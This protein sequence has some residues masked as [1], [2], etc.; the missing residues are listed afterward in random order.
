MS[1][2]VISTLVSGPPVIVVGSGLAGL[3]AATHLINHN[4][5]VQ[6]LD[7]FPKAGGNS[8]KASSGING[9]PTRFQALLDSTEAF[10]NDTIKSAGLAFNQ[11]EGAEKER[12]QRLVK[13]L[14]DDSQSAIYWLADEQGV[15]LSSVSVLG[16]HSAPR[17]H[18]GGPG[19]KPPGFSIVSTLLESLKKSPLFNLKLNTKVTK[20]LK[21]GEE[22]IGVE[23]Q[24][25]T[26]NKKTERIEGP[27]IF[28]SGGFAGDTHGLV[29]QYRPD[30]VG[31]PT[32]NDYREGTQPLLQEIGAGVV[33][34]KEVHVHPT[35]FVDPADPTAHV[36]ILAAEVLRGEGGILLAGT[37]ERFVNELGTRAQVTAAIQ[38]NAEMIPVPADAKDPATQQ[39]EVWLVLDK[40]SAEKMASH[41]GFYRFK[42]LMVDMTIGDLS[43]H[44]PNALETIR[45]YSRNIA[46][47]TPDPFG[48]ASFGS[49]TLEEVDES[50]P[51]TAGR[52]TPV[53]HF[54]MGGV[55]IDSDATVINTE[56]EK[57]EGLWAAGEITGGLHGDNRLG[58]SS[59][60]ECV[61]FGRRAG[62]EAATW[63]KEHY[64][65]AREGQKQQG[66][67]LQEDLRKE[68]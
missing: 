60:L 31:Y 48:R 9:A 39:W 58:G 49:W 61:V 11:A 2:S 63:W 13:T 43:K 28:A 62:N 12:R 51:I 32:T 27:V 22:V 21:E 1:V 59:L 4:V 56:G 52:I 33:D 46:T 66:L 47:S 64:G 8:I 26:D 50:T 30:L 15:D 20:V 45:S 14:V 57:I 25:A 18:R 10:L 35:G 36:K 53:I 29:E 41:L 55:T 17:T 65:E 38:K 23:V 68:L 40:T 44:L 5:P 19:S 3:S 24:D 37:G 7:R 42:K 54:T 16:G 67:K 34:M 6:L